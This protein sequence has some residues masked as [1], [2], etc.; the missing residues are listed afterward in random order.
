MKTDIYPKPDTVSFMS[1]RRLLNS[2]NS[3]MY[4]YIQTHIS[5][6]H[7]LPASISEGI[8]LHS[9]MDTKTHQK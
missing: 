9:I 6:T 4:K 8:M 7:L 3:L 2:K 5:V 1:S